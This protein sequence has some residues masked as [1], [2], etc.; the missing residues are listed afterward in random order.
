MCTGWVD[1]E[2]REMGDGEGGE[3]GLRELRQTEDW[4]S[5]KFCQVSRSS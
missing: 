1:E 5:E 2:E 3:G 4:F